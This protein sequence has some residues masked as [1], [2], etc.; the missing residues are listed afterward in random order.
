MSC[1]LLVS[2]VAF[3]LIFLVPV[4]GLGVSF[5]MWVIYDV[6]GDVVSSD[7]SIIVTNPADYSWNDSIV[8]A[9]DSGSGLL[10][11]N[12]HVIDADGCRVA[13]IGDLKENRIT[14]P[15]LL[16]VDWPPAEHKVFPMS[17]Y[18]YYNTSE[19]FMISTGVSGTGSAI[20]KRTVPE[21]FFL[22]S[23]FLVL[24]GNKVLSH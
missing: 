17:V 21:L 4:S 20:D 1:R 6:N 8:V 9:D 2:F 23:C 15:V 24:L 19:G 14:V 13:R 3:S 7:M 12:G 16:D 11:W 18:I 10:R 5:P 22:V